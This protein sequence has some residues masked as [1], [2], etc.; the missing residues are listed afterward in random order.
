MSYAHLPHP[1][2]TPEYR[3]RM[4][5]Q[6]MR[7]NIRMTDKQLADFVEIMKSQPSKEEPSV[8]H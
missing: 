8:S 2:C 3:L 1:Y 7:F 4:Y 5:T 6:L